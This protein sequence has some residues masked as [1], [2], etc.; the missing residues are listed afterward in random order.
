M[1]HVQTVEVTDAH[2]DTLGHV[3]NVV[4]L[5]WIQDAAADHCRAAGLDLPAIFQETGQAFVVARHEID[6]VRPAFPGTTLSV[7]T[8]VE[9]QRATMSMRQTRV[10]DAAGEVLCRARTVWVFVD[11][12]A[13]KPVRLPKGFKVLLPAES[14]EDPST[15]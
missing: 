15:A 10:K 1:P 3:N 7:E 12:E 13:G 6:Y 2:C 14:P 8:W 9:R 4:Y 11:V 5:Q